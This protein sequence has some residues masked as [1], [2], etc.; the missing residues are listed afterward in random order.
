M[1]IMICVMVLGLEIPGGPIYLAN[2]SEQSCSSDVK[3]WN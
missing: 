3:S 2:G 1:Q